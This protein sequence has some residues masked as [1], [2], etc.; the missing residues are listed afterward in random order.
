MDTQLPDFPE[1][2][3][4]HAWYCPGV[5]Q[6]SGKDLIN[7]HLSFA[8]YNHTAIW[9]DA[10]GLWPRAMRT[11]GH[12]LLNAEKM[13]KSTGA[14]GRQRMRSSAC[15][16]LLVALYDHTGRRHWNPKCALLLW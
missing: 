11:N 8:L 2:H 7:N 15:V 5:D 4:D 12:L 9:P 3:T 16:R 10:P 14:V 1:G 6:V 13:S